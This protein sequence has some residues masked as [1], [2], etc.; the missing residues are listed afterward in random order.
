ML[1][2]TFCNFQDT[3][4]YVDGKK[5]V[6]VTVPEAK[7]RGNTRNDEVFTTTGSY[8]MADPSRAPVMSGSVSDYKT[9]KSSPKLKGEIIEAPKVNFFSSLTGSFTQAA[10]AGAGAEVIGD[11]SKWARPKKT[12]ILYEYEGSAYWYVFVDVFVF[13][14]L[15]LQCLHIYR[16]MRRSSSSPALLCPVLTVLPSTLFSSTLPYAKTDIQRHF[17]FLLLVT[18]SS[19]FLTVHLSLFLP[20]SHTAPYHTIPHD[21]NSK[22]VREALS[23]LDLSVE[24]RP[25]PNARYGFSD[26]LSTRTLGSRTI[27]F[28]VDPGNS[29]GKLGSLG[30]SEKIIEYLFDY[31]GPGVEAIPAT[32]KGKIGG[33][34]PAGSKLI[35]NLKSDNM[36]RKPIELWGFEG[37][38]GVKPVRETLCG[39]ALA[40][41]MVHTAKGS[42]NLKKLSAKAGK[43]D[44]PYMEDP[45]TNTK[46]TGSADIVKYLT[47]TYTTKQ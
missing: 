18:T 31:F 20:V 33:S 34:T 44:T 1:C 36:R 43:T 15:L 7:K 12:L 11:S 37:S 3:K 8:N 24:Y 35:T 9:S 46:L 42:Q 4:N 23:M 30:E 32:L 10:R 19:L 39:L 45:N 21:D 29:M 28:L 26:E 17:L 38:A 6:K 22:R 5:T 13:F 27:P 47:A 40:H 16:L 14:A 41:R 2:S 25:C